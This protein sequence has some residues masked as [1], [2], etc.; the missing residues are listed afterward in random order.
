MYV[1]GT[2]IRTRFIEHTTQRC[3]LFNDLKSM[4]DALQFVV[5]CNC[6]MELSDSSKYIL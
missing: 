5:Y 3:F 1:N 6:A 2:V 4:T